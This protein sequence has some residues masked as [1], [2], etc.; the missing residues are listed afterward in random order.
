MIRLAGWLA[1]LALVATGHVGFVTGS[2][3]AESIMEPATTKTTAIKPRKA[4]R[5]VVVG[6]A[7]AIVNMARSKPLRCLMADPNFAE[8]QISP[9]RR[10]P[11]MA[12]ATLR[13][14]THAAIR[15]RDAAIQTHNG[16]PY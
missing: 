5:H 10:R 9:P 6:I 2:A 13:D 4:I 1:L 12:K 11:E 16:L 15:H 3:R 7:R 14:A 8:V